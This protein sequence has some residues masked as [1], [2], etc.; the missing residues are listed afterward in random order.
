[1]RIAFIGLKGL[2]VPWT[3]IE[4]HVD[5]IARGL[6]AAGHQVTAYVRPHYTDATLKEY[7]GV[8]L[9]HLPTI[10]SKHLDASVHSFLAAVDALFRH[11]HVVHFHCIG[12]GFF[13]FIPRLSGKRVVCT[14]HRLD[15]QSDKWGRLAR[16][17]LRVGEWVVVHAAHRLIVVSKDLEAYFWETYGRR[18][19]F[20]PNGIDPVQPRPPQEISRRWGLAGGDYVL[21]LGRLSPEKRVDWLI[22]AFRALPRP[23]CDGKPVKLVIA[24]GCNATEPYVAALRQSAGDDSRVVF[25]GFVSGTLKEELLSNAALFVLPSRVEGMPIVLLE[26]KAYGICCLASDIPSHRELIH[27]GVDGRLFAAED[28]GDLLAKLQETLDDG[29]ARVRLVAAAR[30]RIASRLLWDDVVAR[31]L[32]VYRG[33]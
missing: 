32:A 21:F 5:R 24:G 23:E 1:M 9:L 31:T 28:A 27:D 20:I 33:V 15:W 26:A 22:R 10:R 8:R 18:A 7:R 11:Y 13:S 16:W 12:P 19:V 4:F 14:V 6:A 2:P 17:A 25:A 30:Q 3:G 29:E